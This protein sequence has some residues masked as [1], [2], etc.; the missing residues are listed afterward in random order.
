MD[1]SSKVP[2]ISI[3][4]SVDKNREIFNNLKEKDRFYIETSYKG[5]IYK[6]LM[7]KTNKEQRYFACFLHLTPY[8]CNN[9][10]CNMCEYSRRAGFKIIR[11]PK[12]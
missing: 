8:L 6:I 3:Y 1:K 7:Y 9:I 11:K 10:D 4:N 2:I 5:F 12:Y